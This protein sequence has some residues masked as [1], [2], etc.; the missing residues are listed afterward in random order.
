MFI[1]RF[2]VSVATCSENL[3]STRSVVVLWLKKSR[4]AA[5]STFTMTLTVATFNVLF[6]RYYTKYSELPVMPPQQRDELMRSLLRQ[7]AVTTPLLLLQ[8]S[9]FQPTDAASV[10]GDHFSYVRA[11]VRGESCGI[12]FD[13]RRFEMIAA[14]P[15]VSHFAD[16]RSGAPMPK[17]ILSALL[18]DKATET[19]VRATSVHVPWA[20]DKRSQLI[21]LQQ[22]QTHLDATRPHES[23]CGGGM[24]RE[25]V[26]GDFNIDQQASADVLA[27]AFPATEGWVEATQNIPWSVAA[28]RGN[29]DKIDF[30]FAKGFSVAA[31][32]TM[33]PE[34]PVDLVKHKALTHPD[35]RSAPPFTDKFC[36][37]HA[38][39]IA[40]LA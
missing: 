8:E 6:E 10:F 40:Q 32:A 37:D 21:Y 20:A 28:A 30:I 29:L 39:L 25:I 7:L 11:A 22:I 23:Q 5:L 1:Y 15:A 17:L 24:L 33:I 4:M 26:T 14:A 34:T 31:E 16:A 12:A 38:V 3:L 13:N 18:L 27:V 9:H 19:T 2:V 35:Y 36:S